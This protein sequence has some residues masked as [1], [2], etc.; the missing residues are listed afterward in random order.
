MEDN[1][2]MEDMR[3]TEE[4]LHQISMEVGALIR[5]IRCGVVLLDGPQ[6]LMAAGPVASLTLKHSKLLKCFCRFV[7]GRW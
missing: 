2:A 7:S 5:E 1:K 4:S 3:R 6:L